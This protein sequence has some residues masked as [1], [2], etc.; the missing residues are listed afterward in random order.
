[1]EYF[2]ILFLVAVILSPLV[3][4][5]ASPGQAK[6]SAF[7]RQAMN[8]GLKVQLVPA[9]DAEES[10]TRPDAVRYFLPFP[11]D[12]VEDLRSSLANWTLVRGQRRGWESAWPEWR[13]FRSEAP[14]HCHTK[15]ASVISQLPDNVYG[16]RAEKDGV[17]V[18]V[19]EKGEIATVQQMVDALRLLL[20]D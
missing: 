20:A 4:L 9:V 14:G 1:M 17:A 16:L 5:K 2:L 7:R 19:R 11:A 8:L 3:A 15:I 13:W 18:F 12:R 10:A 6:V